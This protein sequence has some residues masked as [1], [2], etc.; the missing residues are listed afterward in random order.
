MTGLFSPRCAV[1]S[2]YVTFHFFGMGLPL[3]RST[4]KLGVA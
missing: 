2:E 4:G 3:F 1:K